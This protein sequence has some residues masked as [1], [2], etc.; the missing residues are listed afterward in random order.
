[1]LET[2]ENFPIEFEYIYFYTRSY[3]DMSK[4]ISKL[5]PEEGLSV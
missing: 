4:G 3:L 5:I 1:M 2:Q